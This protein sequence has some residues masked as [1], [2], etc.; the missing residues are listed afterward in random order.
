MNRDTYSWV[1]VL[2]APS[3]LVLSVSRDEA[4][5]ASL[6]NLCQCLTTL[7]IKYFF[8][9]SNLN[10]LSLSLKPFPLVLLPQ[11]LLK[12]PLLSYSPEVN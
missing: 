7:I 10:L 9:I 6:G 5:T 4:P 8:L 1:R 2:S 12:S 11:T 3:S